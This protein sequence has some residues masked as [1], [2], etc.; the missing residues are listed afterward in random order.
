[1]AS[2][3]AASKAPEM[4]WSPTCVPV[5][6][7]NIGEGSGGASCRPAGGLPPKTW[8]DVLTSQYRNH[9]PETLA[10]LLTQG[11]L[12][13]APVG[14][15]T[16]AGERPPH[17]QQGLLP[18]VSD[19]HPQ[20]GQE[21]QSVSKVW[22]PPASAGWGGEGVL[23]SVAFPANCLPPWRHQVPGRAMRLSA[24]LSPLSV[25]N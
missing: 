12:R 17:S 1:M 20:N 25:C 22:S 8:P 18:S 14:L 10:A 5:S 4:P 9:R 2:C 11:R 3:L 16:S 21:L 23:C 19:P 7:P 24:S 6:A 13:R 15:C